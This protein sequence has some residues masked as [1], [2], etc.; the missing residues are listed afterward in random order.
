MPN[1]NGGAV[2]LRHRARP[3]WELDQSWSP[4]G[5]PG[6]TPCRSIRQGAIPRRIS[7][8]KTENLNAFQILGCTENARSK[9]TVTQLFRHRESGRRNANAPNERCHNRRKPSR[10]SPSRECATM[11]RFSH[12]V[13][14]RKLFTAARST[15]PFGRR[16]AR[17]VF[18]KPVV[19]TRKRIGLQFPGLQVPHSPRPLHVH[20]APIPI[21]LGLARAKA[22]ERRDYE[23]RHCSDIPSVEPLGRVT[24]PVIRWLI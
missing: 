9:V 22:G 18:A 24:G 8:Q 2:R 3:Q 7:K 23:S 14:Q 12:F 5:I 6:D 11:S 20:D 4:V 13:V 17:Q 21:G 16:I 19:K 10:S 15:K 1:R